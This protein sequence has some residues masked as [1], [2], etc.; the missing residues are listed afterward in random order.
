MSNNF[1]HKKKKYVIIG[2]C[3]SR[4]QFPKNVETKCS[5]LNERKAEIM[6]DVHV[7]TWIKLLSS[8]LV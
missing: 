2:N 7:K 4:E 5:Q 6:I 1:D 3:S 8:S